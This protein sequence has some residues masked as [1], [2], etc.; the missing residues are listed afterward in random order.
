MLIQGIKRK[1]NFILNHL[2]LQWPSFN[3]AHVLLNTNKKVTL[4]NY[5][6]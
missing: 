6:N 2:F 3:I 1:I 5:L 4:V